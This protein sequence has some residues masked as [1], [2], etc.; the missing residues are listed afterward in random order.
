M[1]LY[2]V[3]PSCEVQQYLIV[4][5]SFSMRLLCHSMP[6]CDHWNVALT[7]SQVNE[8]LKW[9][10]CKVYETIFERARVELDFHCVWFLWQVDLCL[11]WSSPPVVVIWHDGF[12]TKSEK[13]CRKQFS[14]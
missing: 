8:C 2:V 14:T 7:M 12:E 10:I 5:E 3:L 9:E 11:G 1:F 6:P 4:V 13:K